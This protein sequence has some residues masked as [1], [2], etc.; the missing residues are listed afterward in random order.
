[1]TAPP[2]TPTPTPSSQAFFSFKIYP[3]EWSPN[4]PKYCLGISGIVTS[5]FTYSVS[6]T[7]VD[8]STSQPINLPF[9]IPAVTANNFIGQSAI[10]WTTCVFPITI[11][12]TVIVNSATLSQSVTVQHSL[13]SKG[14]LPPIINPPPIIPVCYQVSVF[15]NDA[16]GDFD[17]NDLVLN[18]Q[19]YDASTD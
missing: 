7:V 9:A 18:F 3:V 13:G 17:W 6:G 2:P 12:G 4:R 14:G 8:S 15:N 16:G 1:M 11:S 19:L 10:T 5:E